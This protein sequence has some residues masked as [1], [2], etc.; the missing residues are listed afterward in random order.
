MKLA[1][2]PAAA[3]AWAV[4]GAVWCAVGAA[5]GFACTAPAILGGPTPETTSHVCDTGGSCPNGYDCPPYA[6]PTG[7]CEAQG[8]PS[9]QW[10]RRHPDGGVDVER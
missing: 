2:Y 8:Q 7:P 10:S 6:N 3:L 5:L 4:L 9:M 1:E